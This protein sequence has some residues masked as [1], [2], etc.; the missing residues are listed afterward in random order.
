[1]RTRVSIPNPHAVRASGDR[2]LFGYA[3][4]VTLLLAVFA[5]LYASGATATDTAGSTGTTADR[6]GSQSMEPP[7]PAAVTTDGVGGD[8]APSEAPAT[9]AVAP[10]VPAAAP[11]LSGSVAGAAPTADSPAPISELV[12]RFEDIVGDAVSLPGVEITSS[13]RGLVIS[14]PEAGSFPAGSAEL[15]MSAMSVMADLAGRLH[16][17]PNLVRVEGHT[18]DVPIATVQ[19]ASNWDLSTARATRVV[20]FLIEEGIDPV[21]LAAAGYAEYRP[22]RPNDTPASRARNRRVDIVVLDPVAAVR[23][24]PGMVTP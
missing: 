15:S 16:E 24:E 5:S 2:W 12:G 4:I 10:E 8:V 22:R 11:A 19:F 21:R 3:D 13:T 14:L 6:W 18:D 7:E 20:E 23:E 17:L 1:M 9:E